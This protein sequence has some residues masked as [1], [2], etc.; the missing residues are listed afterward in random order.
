MV[1]RRKAPVSEATAAPPAP[2]APYELKPGVLITFRP[3]AMKQAVSRLTDSVGIK[4]VAFAADFAAQAVD[5]D[6]TRQAGMLV[7]DKIGVAVADLDPDQEASIA[8][9]STDGSAV[10]TVEP[11]PI[12]FAF[13]DGASAELITYLR[14]Y[15]DA[16]NFIYDRA[17]GTPFAG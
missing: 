15:R 6:Q 3:Q 16:V 2:V 8:A 13:A 5:M 4:N 9:V 17:A 14:G 12:F 7:F 10:A 11:E 1:T